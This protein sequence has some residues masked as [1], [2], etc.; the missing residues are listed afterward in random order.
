MAGMGASWALMVIVTWDLV[1]QEGP[2]TIH[3]R[4]TLVRP[5]TTVAALPQ[6]PD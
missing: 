1:T 4:E 2:Y 5:W 3:D 6:I